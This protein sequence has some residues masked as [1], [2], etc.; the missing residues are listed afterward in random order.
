MWLPVLKVALILFLAA[1]VTLLIV[2]GRRQSRANRGDPRL[3]PRGQPGHLGSIKGV[4][5]STPL[6]DWVDWVDW[7]EGPDLDNSR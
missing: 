3:M 1:G 4:P 6:P 5:P 2:V 7:D